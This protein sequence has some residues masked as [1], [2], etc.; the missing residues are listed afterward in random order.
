M[1]GGRKGMYEVDWSLILTQV[2]LFASG[3]L[4]G[5]GLA[6]S[7]K[8]LIIMGLGILVL[9]LFGLVSITV[10]MPAGIL[11]SL[12]ALTYAILSQFVSFSAKFPAFVGGLLVGIVLAV[13]RGM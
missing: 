1:G 8:G 9:A 3:L 4:V 10:N 5:Y 12:S 6:K 13:L 2:V 11:D 7:L